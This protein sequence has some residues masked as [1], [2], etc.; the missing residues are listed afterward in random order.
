MVIMG[1]VLIAIGVLLFMGRFEQL[2]SLGNF[3][4]AGDDRPAAQVGG[5][6]LWIPASG[7]DAEIASAVGRVTGGQL[8]W[9]LS[10]SG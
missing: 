6:S 5:A 4:E 9:G 3:I 8:R 7:T 1:V 10:A 2:A